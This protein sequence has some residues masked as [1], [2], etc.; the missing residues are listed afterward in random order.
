MQL[1]SDVREM[2]A[3]YRALLVTGNG[4]NLS[5]LRQIQDFSLSRVNQLSVAMHKFPLALSDV[6]LQYKKALEYVGSCWQV[7]DCAAR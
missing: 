2:V 3:F 5:E 4:E 6:S 1:I 7:C